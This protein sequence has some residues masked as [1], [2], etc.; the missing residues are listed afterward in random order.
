MITFARN[1]ILSS[2]TVVRQFSSLIRSLLSQERQ[3]IGVIRNNEME[4]VILSI[5][6]YERL[7]EQ[8]QLAEHISL[9]TTI[10]QRKDVL[11]SAY[12]PFEDVLKKAGLSTDE[13]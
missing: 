9:A 1:E 3:K 2:T 8:A 10:N 7:N 6:E 12:I 4:A 11:S 13:L 5:D